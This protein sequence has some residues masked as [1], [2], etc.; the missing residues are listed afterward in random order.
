M[1]LMTADGTL[2]D[3]LMRAKEITE[4]RDTDGQ[5]LGYYAPAGVADQVPAVQA[6]RLAALFDPEELKR[7]KASTHPGYTFEQVMEHIRSLEKQS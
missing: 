4:I 6:L 2:K 3:Y 5:V 1:A 7:R